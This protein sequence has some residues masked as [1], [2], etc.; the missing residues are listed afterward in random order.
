MYIQIG[1][2]VYTMSELYGQINQFANIILQKH[3][4][5]TRC[6][7]SGPFLSIECLEG[8]RHD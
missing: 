4:L 8:Y 6:V 3:L 5:K 7:H 2:V 1:D